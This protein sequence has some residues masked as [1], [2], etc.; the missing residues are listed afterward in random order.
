MRS[1]DKARHGA[2]RSH[3]LRH[4]AASGTAAMRRSEARR[5]GQPAQARRPA[6]PHREPRAKG[7]DLAGRSRGTA[8]PCPCRSFPTPTSQRAAPKLSRPPSC[9]VSR[10]RSRVLHC[11]VG[12]ARVVDR[13]VP[14]LDVSAFGEILWDCFDEAPSAHGFGDRFVRRLGG[15]PANVAATVARLGLRSTVLG[16]VGNDA[17]G[18]DLRAELVRAG[19]DERG[20]LTLPERTGLTFVSRGAGGQPSFLF[21]RHETADMSV[22]SHHV[23]PA[24][25]DARYLVVGTSTFVERKLRAASR[26]FVRMGVDGGGALVV[27][28]N[29]RAHLWKKLEGLEQVCDAL[30]RKASIVKASD[31]DVARLPVADP[32]RWLRGR[33]KKAVL[34]RTHGEG[35]ATAIGAFGEVRVEAPSVRC[36]D[37]TGAGDA[38][39]SGV[40][41]ALSAL[42]AHPGSERFSK[43]ESWTDALRLGCAL[44]AKATTAEGAVTALEDLSAEVALLS[45]LGQRDA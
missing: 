10:V 13:A 40:L 11:H 8:A 27:D 3:G 9:S 18:L 33:C 45:A 30:V 21:Y 42:R 14:S 7:E 17:F 4:N 24:M 15:A 19:V 36:V 41:A 25:V 6:G 32:E 5:E 39:L 44:G 16:G 12:L 2:M 35:G 29:V 22:A 26:R 34:V 23:H 31:D 1:G 38:F 43:A 20:I 37:A 28:L